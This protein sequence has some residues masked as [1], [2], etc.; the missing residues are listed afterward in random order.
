M[1][2]TAGAEWGSGEQMALAWS[3]KL[4]RQVLQAGL[5]ARVEAVQPQT[6]R[7]CECS[8]RRHVHSHGLAGWLQP[9]AVTSGGVAS[10]SDALPESAHGAA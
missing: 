2:R 6:E 7:Q 10:G 9:P 5:R 1:Q 3:R 8:G 4:G